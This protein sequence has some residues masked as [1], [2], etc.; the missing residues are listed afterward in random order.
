MH[1]PKQLWK[2]QAMSNPIVRAWRRLMNVLGLAEMLCDT[3]RYDHPSACR[4]PARPNATE[5]KDYKAR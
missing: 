3:C 2:V 5:C 1:R 4:N